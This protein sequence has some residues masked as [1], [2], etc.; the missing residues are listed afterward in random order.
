M[1]FN[2]CVA[3]VNDAVDGRLETNEPSRRDGTAVDRPARWGAVTRAWLAP[4]SAEMAKRKAYTE[5]CILKNG[6]RLGGYCCEL[7]FCEPL[8]QR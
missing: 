2:S 6:R 8:V 1:L 4:N 5:C 3:I 7:C